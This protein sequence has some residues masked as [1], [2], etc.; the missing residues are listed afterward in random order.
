MV[1]DGPSLADALP[2][3]SHPGAPTAAEQIAVYRAW[4]LALKEWLAGA[5]AWHQQAAL[6]HRRAWHWYYTHK[7]P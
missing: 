6:W 3:G 1:A 5:R 2:D 4:G 7:E